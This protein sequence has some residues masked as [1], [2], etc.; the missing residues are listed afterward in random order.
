MAPTVNSFY[1]AGLV[2][3]AHVVISGIHRNPGGGGQ[4]GDKPKNKQKRSSLPKF[5]AAIAHEWIQAR[6]LEYLVCLF[7]GCVCVCVCVCVCMCVCAYVGRRGGGLRTKSPPP[8]RF[9]KSGCNELW[10]LY[11]GDKSSINTYNSTTSSRTI[12]VERS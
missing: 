11:P 7:F 6:Q 8:P 2:N 1:W 12:S 10:M 4:N 9:T 3:I 5:R